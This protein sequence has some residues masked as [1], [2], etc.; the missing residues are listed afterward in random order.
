MEP[1]VGSGA[2]VSDAEVIKDGDT[3]AFAA[4]VIDASKDTPIIVDFWAPWCGPCKQLSPALEKIVREAGGKVRLVKIN[5]D[6]NPELAQ[7]LRVQ[8]IPTIFAFKDGQ[9]VDGFVGAL[10]DSQL[11]SFV[12]R[13]AGPIGPSK[14][15]LAV[16]EAKALVEAG[17]V[18]K[19]AKT[20]A[21][22]LKQ[23]PGHPAATGGLA[24]C[25]VAR[26]DLAQARALLAT[27]ANDHSDHPDI[28]GAQARLDL[29]E[30][31]PEVGETADLERRLE[32]DPNDH[33]ARCD[34]ATALHGAGNDEDAIDQL[35]EAVRRDREWNDQAARKQLLKIFEALGTEHAL[36]VAGR[37]NLSSILFS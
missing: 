6:E 25:H 19:A 16:E 21:K 27:V 28:V 3:Q 2:G 24:S 31:T 7:Q 32:A 30:Q 18:H 15:E 12:E 13:L 20:Y 35:L 9:P 37:R 36:T 14:V 1:L 22:A 11:K 29:A 33:Q 10:P 8:S 4:D 5:V 17:D 34:L 23:E 26:G